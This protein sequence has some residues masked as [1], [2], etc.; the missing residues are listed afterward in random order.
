MVLRVG[1]ES[2]LYGRL[3]DAQD[4]TAVLG[5]L[6]DNAL[7]AAVEGPDPRWVEVDLLWEGSTLHLAVAD[8]G[9]GVPPASMFSP[10][11]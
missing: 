4:A 1:D 9:T 11:A 5:N 2:A 3:N 10:R 8:S 6:I 7:G